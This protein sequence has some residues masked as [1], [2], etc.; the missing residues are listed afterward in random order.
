MQVLK[1]TYPAG[2]KLTHTKTRGDT[3]QHVTLDLSPFAGQWIVIQDGAVIEH[4]PDLDKIAEKARVRGVKR[5]RVLYV[6]P[7]NQG[8]V[9]LGL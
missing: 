3:E 5:P 2:T 7:R 8:T 9:K 6:E 1:W 4:G